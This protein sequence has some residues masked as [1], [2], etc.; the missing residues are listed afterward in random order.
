MFTFF[1]L[2]PI[3][4]INFE[5]K[6]ILISILIIFFFNTDI[7]FSQ[8]APHGAT[9][10]TG[11]IESISSVNQG[12]VKTIS[13]GDSLIGAQNCQML[14]STHVNHLGQITD[15][16]TAYMYS[17]SG[18]VYNYH[19]GSF[20]ILF[21]FSL[22]PGQSWQTIAPY[23]SPF[24]MSGNPPD[25]MVQII[26]DSVSSEIISGITKKLLY[27]HSVANDWYFLNPIIEDIG[28]MGGLYP[29]I[30]DWMDVE[31]PLFRCY[32]DSTIQY[33]VDAGIP[34]EMLLNNVL[35]NENVW[36][37]R[38]FPNPSDNYLNIDFIKKEKNSFFV[39]INELGLTVYRGSSTET[40][41]V[42][43][44]ESFPSGI[45]SIVI[46]SNAKISST[47]FIITHNN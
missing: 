41:Q 31:I 37:I 27:V 17:D 4:I 45:Y 22:S 13:I 29:F 2:E 24:T 25:T 5:M 35:E 36:N 30:Y 8:W 43:N 10:H 34:C 11:I 28:S 33:Q 20:Y 26:V 23:P 16:D 38:I 9:W 15:V 6:K 12:Y 44:T 40:S 39:I 46:F 1:T 32:N 14:E 7:S 18:K 3:F 21:D 47:N 19:Y 42:L